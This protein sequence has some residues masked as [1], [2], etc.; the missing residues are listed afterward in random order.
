MKTGNKLPIRWLSFIYDASGYADEARNMVLHLDE[1]KYQIKIS[2]VGNQQDVL[3]VLDAETRSRLDKL[4]Q[5]EN[6]PN[7]VTV[8]WIPGY[9]FNRDSGAVVNIGRTMF[10]TDRIPPDW[11]TA[12]NNMDEIWV[13][14][15]FNRE[16]FAGAGVN[17]D[18]IFVIPGGIDAGKYAAVTPMDLPDRKGFNFLA[19]FEWIYRKGWDLLLKAYLTE[20]SKKDDVALVLKVNVPHFSTN[21]K[22]QGQLVEYIHNLGFDLENIPEVV[23]I[24]EYMTSNQMAALYA[25]CDTFVLPTRGEGWGRP[26]MEAM[27]TG[28]PTIGTRWSGHLEFMN[29]DNSYLIDIDGLEDVP[30]SVEISFYQGHRWARPSLEHTMALMREVC[31]NKEQAREKGKKARQE[32]IKKWSWGKVAGKLEQRLEKYR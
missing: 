25:A 7:P 5:G 20:F 10:E 1:E 6:Q 12:C 26:Y 29:D 28:L 18:K 9:G 15:H 22:V 14:T 30:P 32:M 19:V 8:Q 13:P 17:Q 21:E 24:N 3:G 4:V 23:L 2:P 31:E 16:T 27:A 11:V